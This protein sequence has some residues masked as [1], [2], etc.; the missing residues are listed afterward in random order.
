MI[1]DGDYG[2]IGGIKIGR[3]NRGTRRKPASVPLYPPQTP[4]TVRT[5]TRAAAVGSQ[6]LTA[7][8]MAWPKW[9]L[10]RNLWLVSCLVYS[11]CS[12]LEH[13]TSVKRFVSLQFLNRRHSIGLLGRVISSSQGRYITQTQNKHGHPCLEWDSNRAFKRPKTV[14][15]LRPRGHCDRRQF[16]GSIVNIIFNW[17]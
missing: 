1:G 8:A 17:T 9:N 2:E 3:E 10:L 11:C 15:A 7:W 13:R 16:M 12:H 5:R 6:R 4:H 14:H